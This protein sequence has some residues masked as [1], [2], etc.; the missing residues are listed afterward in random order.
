MILFRMETKVEYIS[1]IIHA[2]QI[3]AF[4]K[5]RKKYSRKLKFIMKVLKSKTSKFQN[6]CVIW[7]YSTLAQFLFVGKLF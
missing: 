6:D 7:F 4:W 3:Y 2:K 1:K 5:I